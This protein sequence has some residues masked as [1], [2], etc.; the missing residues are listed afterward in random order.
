MACSR[1]N[2]VISKKNRR[3][4]VW[5]AARPCE[6]KAKFVTAK[7]SLD[8]RE[9]ALLA[10]CSAE[11]R[12]SS[13]EIRGHRSSSPVALL[14]TAFR[15]HT[16]SP[17]AP[18]WPLTSP[19]PN[20]RCVRQNCLRTDRRDISELRLLPSEQILP[21]PPRVGTYAAPRAQGSY[22]TSPARVSTPSRHSDRPPLVPPCPSA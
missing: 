12:L 22:S 7:P 9:E 19:P 2:S 16:R 20:P 11:Q 3:V 6:R 15:D 21:D 8:Q 17:S 13:Q 5:N 18:A 10:L 1:R 14:R 4:R